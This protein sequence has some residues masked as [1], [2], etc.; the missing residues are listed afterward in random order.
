MPRAGEL[1]EV[2]DGEE[3]GRVA[4]L[5]DQLELAQLVRTFADTPSGYRLAAPA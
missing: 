5:G 2:V 1:D 3:V 4:Q